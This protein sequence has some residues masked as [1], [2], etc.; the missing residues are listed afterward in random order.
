MGEADTCVFCGVD[1]EWLDYGHYVD[2][3]NRAG[4]MDLCKDCLKELKELLKGK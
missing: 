3:E 1:V 2:D 4:N